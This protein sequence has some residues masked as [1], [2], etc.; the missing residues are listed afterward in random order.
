VNHDQTVLRG[1]DDVPTE[2]PGID[3]DAAQNTLTAALRAAWT[4]SGGTAG[5]LV[6]SAPAVVFL[7]ASALGGLT[8]AIVGAGVTAVIAFAYRLA[9]R[10]TLGGALVG[11][12]LA[13]ACALL[14]ALTGEARGFFLLPTA[15]PAVIFLVCLGTVIARRP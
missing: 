10:E 6:A 3:A 7:V 14:A 2:P 4:T 5:V 15:L 9:R 13:A 11:L 12:I 8:A 1:A